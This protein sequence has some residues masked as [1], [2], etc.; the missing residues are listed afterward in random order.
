MAMI[1]RSIKVTVTDRIGLLAELTRKIKDTG[2]NIL[3]LCAWSEGNRGNMLAITD[4]NP[5]VCAAIKDDADSCVF[6]E[7]VMVTAKNV[8]GA[9]G[10]IAQK[11]AAAGVGINMVYCTAGHAPAATFVLYT[12]DNAKAAELV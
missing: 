3:A 2:V 6:E 4:N 1:C 9:L 10:E 11:L 8:P 12:T 5:K 7:A